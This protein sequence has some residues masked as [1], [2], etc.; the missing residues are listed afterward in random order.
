MSQATVQLLKEAEGPACGRDCSTEGKENKCV[1][2]PLLCVKETKAND[3]RRLI[4]ERFKG[5]LRTIKALMFAV[6]IFF[7]RVSE[8]SM[9]PLVKVKGENLES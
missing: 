8:A 9:G 6:H 5:L 7:C 3:V 2:H 1:L 4:C